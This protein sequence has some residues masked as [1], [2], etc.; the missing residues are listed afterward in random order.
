MRRRDF[1]K[2][3]ILG[4]ALFALSSRALWAQSSDARI[5][6]L[7]DEPLGVISPNVYGHFT[8]HIG[9]VI[10][11]GVWVGPNSKI[12]NRFG[13]R[14]ALVDRLKEIGVP[15]I[16][17]P[18]GCFADS[19]DWKDG[20]GPVANRP[21]RT[22]FWET[23]PDAARLHLKGPQVF[24]PILSVR[25]SLYNSAGRAGQNPIL[26]RIFEAFRQ[27]T[28]TVG[29]NTAIRRREVQPW[30]TCV[31]LQASRTH[32]GYVIGALATRVGD[33]VATLG[34]GLRVGVPSFYDVGS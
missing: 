30:R 15:I 12:P 19:Y 27:W 20:I 34:P 26:Q 23:E 7:L 11:D 17:W 14:T 4:S 32:F 8:E 10:Y 6:I 28:L 13:I 21:R 5:E 25:M 18:G 1:L 33:A 24:N 31:V 22:N 2:D 29:W 9:G 16:R 3:S